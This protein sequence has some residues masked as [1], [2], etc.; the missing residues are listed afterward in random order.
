MTPARRSPARTKRFGQHFLIAQN[1]SE[2]IVSLAN[3][4]PD[5]DVVLEIGQGRDH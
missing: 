1:V 4:N 3:L 2:R 5:S